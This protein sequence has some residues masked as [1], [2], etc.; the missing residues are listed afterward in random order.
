MKMIKDRIAVALI[1]ASLAAF[2]VASEVRADE[3]DHHGHNDLE[4]GSDAAGSGALVAE[5]N[6]ESVVR[7]DYS[8]TVG[9]IKLYSSE[10]PG[11]G[12]AEDEAPELYQL[13]AGTQVDLTIV[14]I[15]EGLSLQIGAS[16]L[17]APGDTGTLGT[18]DGTAGEDG[19]LHGH[20]NF[21]LTV[22]DDALTVGG[23]H[24]GQISF[25]LED[26]ADAYSPSDVYT[27][28]VTNGYLYM[29]ESSDDGAKCQKTIG[30]ATGRLIGQNYKA[31]AK[32]LDSI[33]EWKAEVGDIED[34]ATP[35]KVGRLCSTDADRGLVAKTTSNF[36]KAVAK[37]VKKCIG[38]LGA[39][40]TAATNAIGPN[41]GLAWCRTQE[42]IGASYS[43]ALED[44]AHVL[45]DEDEEAAEE[46]FPCIRESQG[47]TI[48]EDDDDGSVAG[49]FV[50]GALLY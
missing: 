39:D 49:A 14:A 44:L 40:E 48:P 12:G 36:D 9:V 13:N 25:V 15:S 3:E 45:F 17:T 31:L 30:S 6:F 27:F 23:F 35:A 20:G 38:Q 19:A 7:T 29:E 32:C 1:S 16:S 8:N 18:T 41:I 33:Q 37:S 47:S 26:P 34:A 28:T 22:D 5:F 11:W 42:M 46:A 10:T 4:I 2:G 50:D 43:S 21:Q 24:D